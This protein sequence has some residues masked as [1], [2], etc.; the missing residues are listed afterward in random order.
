MSDVPL[1]VVMRSHNDAALLPRTLAAL[2]AQEGFAVRLIV[3]ESAS[4]DDSPQ[5]LRAHGPDELREL[6][7]GGY[8]SSAVLNEGVA[9]AD[10]PLVA[11]LNSDAIML[12]RRCL[13]HLVAA[14]E[15][16]PGLAGVFARQVPR[17][18]A[19]VCTRLDYHVAFER[20]PELGTDADAMSLVCS[21]IRR[22]AWEAV[23]FDARLTYAEDVVWSHR[24]R[25]FGWRTR[26]VSEAVVE[27]SHDYTRSE[28]FR[29]A[30]GEG[31]AFASLGAAPLGA[32]RGVWWPL[33]RRCLRDAW[34]C[35]RPG[36][37]AA[38]ARLPR[39]RWP[40]LRGHWRGLRAGRA[41]FDADPASRQPRPPS[42]RMR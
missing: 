38:I 24:V 9:L 33:L 32:V 14:M 29:R 27:H 8:W 18:G 28:R 25:E 39:H 7:S 35:R 40:Y 22:E 1:T 2:R 37:G 41:R 12:H 10:T 11:F 34:R 3:F 19:D 31:A 26:Y 23:P 30:F 13:A 42:G 6:P 21:A 17:P 20:R 16:D 4:E 36:L 5:I 15:E